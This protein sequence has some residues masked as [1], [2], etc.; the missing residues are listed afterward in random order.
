[1]KQKSIE[2]KKLKSR[3][4]AFL[5][6][7]FMVGTI[8]GGALGAII[9]GAVDN[10]EEATESA[11]LYGTRDGEAL[12]NSGEPSL[13]YVI[14]RDF[15]YIDCPLSDELQEFTYYLCKEY[16][17]D[18]N[19]AM[20][21]M[22]VESSF[23]PDAISSTNDYGLMQINKINHE[24]L[25]NELTINDFLNPYQNI[26]AGLYML[27]ELFEKYDKANLVLMAYNCGE[28]G[29]STLWDNG[30]YETSYSRKVLEKA[31]EY[32]QERSL[33]E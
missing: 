4:I 11:P 15:Q 5:V 32:A 28:Y 9:A 26:R 14:P 22:F 10:K 30:I 24:R 13:D 8:I 21:V 31:D 25:S 20:A 18:F 19:F 33:P 23:H 1:M 12:E 3:V 2:K 6:C 16:Y 27:R 7:L 29:A 17:I